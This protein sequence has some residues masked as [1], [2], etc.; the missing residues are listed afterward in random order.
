MTNDEYLQ[1]ILDSQLIST[2]SPE[3]TA[4]REHREQVE[5][6]ISKE[7][8]E[9]SP[10]IRYGGSKAKGTMIK[11]SYDLDII[12]YFECDDDKAGSSLK[13]IYSNVSAALSKEFYVYKKTSALRLQSKEASTRGVDFHIDVVPGRFTDE[14]KADCYLYLSSGDKQRL[15]TNLQVHLDHVIGSGVRDAIRLM[16]LWKSRNRLILKNFVLEL[17]VV[18]LLSGMKGKPVSSQLSH[19]WEAFRD[20]I[21]S[22]TVEDPANPYGNDLSDLLAQAKYELTS[23]ATR[24]LT[25]IESRGWTVVY[26]E[27]AE[28][29][30]SVEILRQAA[31]AATPIKP[32][33]YFQ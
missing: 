23:V 24:T 16:K 26:G 1:A 14:N 19:V 8:S 18:D 20:N 31:G 2:D 25:D 17:L 33:A 27:V 5:T 21:D 28:K 22:L 6:L 11:E 7:F 13:E 29:Q 4:M 3:M 15:K 9:S 12:C 32:W 10:T 30:A